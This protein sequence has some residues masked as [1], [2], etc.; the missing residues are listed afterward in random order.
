MPYLNSVY[1]D[2]SL[3]F[4][5]SQSTA[6][7]SRRLDDA[8]ILETLMQI[9]EQICKK[10]FWH[11]Q[12]QSVK[13]EIAT[14]TATCK[15]ISTMSTEFPDRDT[16]DK[17]QMRA[18]N[19]RHDQAKE[20]SEGYTKSIESNLL[21]LQGNLEMMLP[22]IIESAGSA[23][24]ESYD[25]KLA[26]MQARISNMEKSKAAEEIAELKNLLSGQRK[27]YDKQI[28][29]LDHKLQELQTWK[30]NQTEG[31]ERLRETTIS[32]GK[33]IDV[34]KAGL[35]SI[36]A[37]ICNIGS[38]I[39]KTE[40]R[41]TKASQDNRAECRDLATK[42]STQS[43]S[44][45]QDFADLTRKVD[46][47]ATS[48]SA[49]VSLSK[50]ML[51]RLDKLD[52]AMAQFEGRVAELSE[53]NTPRVDFGALKTRVEHLEVTT[54]GLGSK[55]ETS[56]FER[57]AAKIE[58]LQEQIQTSSRLVKT[59][60]FEEQLQKIRTLQQQIQDTTGLVKK[61]DFEQHSDAIQKLQEFV[62]HMQEA[63]STLNKHADN[64]LCLQEQVDVMRQQM[65]EA[66]RECAAIG[67]STLTTITKRV[68]ISVERLKRDLSVSFGQL[69]NES[70]DKV[71]GLERRVEDI[72]YD[73]AA[74]KSKSQEIE[75]HFR[76]LDDF[77]RA[78]SRQQET[79]RATL[80]NQQGASDTSR[81]DLER[82]QE[83]HQQG[84]NYLKETMEDFKHQIHGLLSWQRG[85]SA[86][87]FVRDAAHKSPNV[88]LSQVT[89]LSEPLNAIENQTLD[90]SQESPARKRRKL[91]V[92]SGEM[93]LDKPSATSSSDPVELNPTR[94]DPNFSSQKEADDSNTGF[95]ST[96]M[97]TNGMP[98]KKS[99]SSNRA[100]GPA[101]SN[102]GSLAAAPKH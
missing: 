2:H 79:F 16:F 91:A 19:K 38:S 3:V 87:R 74:I 76:T 89:R 34:L 92:S 23:G 59:E 25:R 20:K 35:R 49:N 54:K 39:E 43:E 69:I 58:N 73:C 93:L 31:V 78:L 75:G 90:V 102:T 51:V 45:K 67:T 1:A 70:R 5:I 84:Q 52:G 99:R 72:E 40:S 11:S 12:L 68:G 55:V 44:H 22:K 77:F 6:K 65:E 41:I 85:F 60:E 10:S 97:R 36:K 28:G 29:S 27:H 13:Q 56:E 82:L 26:D 71:D 66:Q 24:K 50:E 96:G 95:H 83:S 47:S 62:Q 64:I 30:A 18:L 100:S 15:S 7:E 88:L 33:S 61:R 57:Q 80:D 86:P 37:E 14:M 94:L 101:P 48:L 63:S 42:I 4:P 32:Q 53:A 8:K 17:P 21:K 81:T 46:G 9:S 98:F